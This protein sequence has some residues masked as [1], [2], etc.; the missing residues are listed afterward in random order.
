MHITSTS[1]LAAL[2]EICVTASDGVSS[3]GPLHCVMTMAFLYL[4]FCYVV[5]PPFAEILRKTLLGLAIHFCCV[6]VLLWRLEVDFTIRWVPNRLSISNRVN[7][8]PAGLRHNRNFQ[9]ERSTCSTILR[10]GSTLSQVHKKLS[11]AAPTTLWCECAMLNAESQ[12]CLLSDALTGT[13]S[14]QRI[15]GLWQVP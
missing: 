5:L 11:T 13:V 15:A 6:D 4:H 3:Q 8:E 10:S 7:R 2:A 1:E 12:H 14:W 9:A